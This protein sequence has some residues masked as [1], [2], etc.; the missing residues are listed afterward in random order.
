MYVIKEKESQIA[1]FCNNLILVQVA[2]T[3]HLSIIYSQ[4]LKIFL[5]LNE[6]VN[7]FALHTIIHTTH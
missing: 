6:K 4:I 7:L 3:K 5:Y 1:A 2:S